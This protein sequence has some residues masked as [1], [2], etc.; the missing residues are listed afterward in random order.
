MAGLEDGVPAEA[1]AAS[2]AGSI[3][4]AG[5]GSL[6]FWEKTPTWHRCKFD[7]AGLPADVHAKLKLRLTGMSKGSL[8]LNG[9]NLGRY[10]Q[11][12]PQEDYKIPLAWLKDV[13]EL[14]LFDEEGRLPAKVKLLFDEQT[15]RSWVELESMQ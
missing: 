10:W 12:G 1:G 5:G 3:T 14:V 6:S 2:E 15:S 9:I 11:I 7:W 13:N 4:Q 8:W